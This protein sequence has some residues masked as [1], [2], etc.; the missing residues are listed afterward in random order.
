[1]MAVSRLNNKFS[2]GFNKPARGVAAV[3]LL[4]QTVSEPGGVGHAR[5]CAQALYV[6]AKSQ[7][8]ALEGWRGRLS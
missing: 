5:L 4:L 7:P 1:M 2:E 8:L 3:L 6:T